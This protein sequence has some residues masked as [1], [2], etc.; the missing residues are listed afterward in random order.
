[1]LLTVNVCN[2]DTLGLGPDVQVTQTGLVF[3]KVDDTLLSEREIHFP[4]KIEIPLPLLNAENVPECDYNPQQLSVMAA[5]GS[6]IKRS[7]LHNFHLVMQ[8]SI[9]SKQLKDFASSIKMK[10][11]MVHVIAKNR[12][13][14]SL[15]HRRALRLR[16]SFQYLADDYIT[17]SGWTESR[18]AKQRNWS[19][20]HFNITK[21]RIDDLG[22]AV[23]ANTKGIEVI[24]GILC[25]QKGL[26]VQEYELEFQLQ[27]AETLSYVALQMAQLENSEL[28]MA[29]TQEFVHDFCITHFRQNKKSKFCDLVNSRSLF[30]CKLKS[31]FLD[32]TLENVILNVHVSTPDTAVSTHTIMRVNTIPVFENNALNI[33]YREA[34]NYAWSLQ[35]SIGYIGMAQTLHGNQ[36]IA[37]DRLGCS[38]RKGSIVCSQRAREMDTACLVNI[39]EKNH[40]GIARTC[41]F[42]KV[43]TDIKCF[44]SRIQTGIVLSTIEAK[45]I[46]SHIF[47]S[48]RPK[49][50]RDQSRANT[51]IFILRNNP[52]EVK[53]VSCNNEVLRTVTKTAMPE[54][55]IQVERPN[56][57]NISFTPSLEHAQL[58]DA[59]RTA[60]AY[61]DNFNNT[62]VMHSDNIQLLESKVKSMS[63]WQM[64]T[65]GACTVFVLLFILLVVWIISKCVTI[66][67]KCMATKHIPQQQ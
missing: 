30:T 43:T 58:E 27:Y 63:W 25:D 48:R 57:L 5:I 67:A 41:R 19:R 17:L 21:R 50:F 7:I 56:S 60:H 66:I 54:I 23:K 32:K 16:R 39:L 6:S 9:S 34:H 61:L 12:A 49:V 38:S 11:T 13:G 65:L 59:I 46:H 8:N 55:S 20:S 40:A 28:P 45:N 62:A 10:T 53:T 44:S 14:R 26:S 52:T 51:G 47:N 36:T 64:L 22:V 37:F 18:L 33:S 2:C 31:V 15:R 42:H 1:M 3:E 29:V 24:H 35:T 4:L